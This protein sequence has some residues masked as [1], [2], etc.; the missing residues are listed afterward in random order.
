MQRHDVQAFIQNHFIK[1]IL[2]DCSYLTLNWIPIEFLL[3]GRLFEYHNVGG[4]RLKELQNKV[5]FR[6]S[7]N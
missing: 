3:Q 2:F 1:K 5:V 6:A 4:G 7:V